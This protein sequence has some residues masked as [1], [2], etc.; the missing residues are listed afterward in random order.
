MAAW[1]GQGLSVSPEVRVLE[2]WSTV[3]GVEEVGL[4]R[5]KI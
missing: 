4:L 2:A 1:F 5:G 3:C